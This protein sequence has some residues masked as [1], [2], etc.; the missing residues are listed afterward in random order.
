MNN[1]EREFLISLVE[2]AGQEVIDRAEDLVGNGDGICDF[3][4]WLRF[5][6][7]SN[8]HIDELPRVEVSRVHSVRNS[9]KAF[10]EY[11]KKVNNVDYKQ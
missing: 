9:F 11:Y 10:E 1:A 3:D 2:A 4:I 7:D 6:F 5:S 8:G